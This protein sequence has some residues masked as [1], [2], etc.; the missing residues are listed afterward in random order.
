M[1]PP[2]RSRKRMLHGIPA[3]MP[4]MAGPLSPS[5]GVGQTISNSVIID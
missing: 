4:A 2:S 5:P 1:R 3:A